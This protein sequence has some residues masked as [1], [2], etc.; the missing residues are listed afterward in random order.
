MNVVPADV[1]LPLGLDVLENEKLVANN[2]HS[3]L[4]AAHHGWSVHI[5]RKHGRTPLPHEE[6]EINLF[7]QVRSYQAVSSLKTSSAREIVRIIET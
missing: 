2:D 4:R 6:V 7:Y 5:T 3:E 1:P